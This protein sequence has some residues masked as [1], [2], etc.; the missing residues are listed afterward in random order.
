[1]KNIFLLFLLLLSIRLNGQ[2]ITKSEKNLATSVY[3]KSGF[4]YYAIRD[5]VISKEKYQGTVVPF[6]LIWKQQRE[7]YDWQFSGFYQQGSTIKNYNV[8]CDIR[9]MQLSWDYLYTVSR[10]TLFSKQLNLEVGPSPEIF[11][12]FRQQDIVETRTELYSFASLISM[13]ANARAD[14]TISNKI[15]LDIF[16][17][18]SLLS[19]GLR[20]VDFEKSDEKFMKP[21]TALKGLNY[22]QG[23][24][25]NYSI[26]SGLALSATYQLNITRISA[27]EY[28]ISSNDNFLLVLSYSF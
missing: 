22:N 17:R 24:S 21:L 20:M 10:G 23:I 11:V 28:F 7:N 25:L 12:H 9:V 3:V 27:W 8:A 6:E 5:E 14:Y 19:V 1:M 16:A 26:F 15:G 4:G 18:L 13:A 2:K